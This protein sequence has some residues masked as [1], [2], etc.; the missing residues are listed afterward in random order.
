[1]NTVKILNPVQSEFSQVP[2]ALWQLPI[3]IDAKA[4]MAYLLSFRDASVIRV[5]LIEQTLMI[6]RDKRQKAMRELEQVGLVAREIKRVNGR[7]VTASLTVTTVPILRQMVA[8]ADHQESEKRRAPDI[9]AVGDEK[10]RAPEIPADGK[11][12]PVERIFRPTRGGKSGPL[13][14]TNTN[15]KKPAAL[16]LDLVE[17]SPFQKSALLAGKSVLI[18]GEMGQEGSPQAA[19]LRAAIVGIA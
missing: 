16:N 15:T 17:L 3:S 6:G 10:H 9:Q 5:A 19:R 18:G 11:S 4:V 2:N 14:N 8:K 7:I 12:G 1:M 13:N